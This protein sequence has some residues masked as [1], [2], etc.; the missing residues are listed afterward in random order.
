MRTVAGLL[1]L[2]GL[3]IAQDYN[4]YTDYADS[5]NQDNLYH[6]YAKKQQVKADGG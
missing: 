3:T 5:Y 2:V 6:D 4:D 1:L